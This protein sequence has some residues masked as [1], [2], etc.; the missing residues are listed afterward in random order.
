MAAILL[1]AGLL[2]LICAPLLFVAG[3]ILV[4]NDQPQ[5]SDAIVVLSTGIEYYS[6]RV[7]AAA[8]YR[9]GYGERVVINGSRK[10]KVLRELEEKG[11]VPVSTWYE[12][13]FRLLSLLGVPRDRVLTISAEDAYDTMSESKIAG[14]ELLKAGL[15]RIIITT[16]KFHTR[17]ARYIWQRNF[18]DRLSIRAIPA[19]IAP[20]NSGAWRKHGT[21]DSLGALR[22]RCLDLLLLEDRLGN[23]ARE[24]QGIE[25][26]LAPARIQ[27]LHSGMCGSSGEILPARV[28]RSAP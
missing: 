18:P 20:Y 25:S 4:V 3:Q 12:D 24:V 17:C 15:A 10:S 26:S 7:E 8:L 27:W 1:V 9:E 13:S 28:N 6:R 14:R 16:S 5:R 21:P 11:F 23:P 2:Y 19:R 22:V